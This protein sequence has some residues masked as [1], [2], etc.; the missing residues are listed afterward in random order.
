MRRLTMGDRVRVYEDPATENILEGVAS[1]KR[2][3]GR[4]LGPYERW[5]VEFHDE[6]GGEYERSVRPAN[7]V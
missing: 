4:D 5:L 3:I 1:L 6:P 2:R 7:R